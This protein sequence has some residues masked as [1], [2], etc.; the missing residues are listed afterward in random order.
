ME[1]TIEGNGSESVEEIRALHNWL[2]EARLDDIQSI[3]QKILPPKPGEQG[4]EL[5]D[6]LQIVLAAPA[7][8]TLIKCIKDYI[9]ATR[10]KFKITVKTEKGSVTIDAQNAKTA[11]LE[12]MAKSLAPK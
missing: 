7:V 6:V 12:N 2:R 3:S 10:P 11:D 9:V 8:I 4:P 5:L 1:L